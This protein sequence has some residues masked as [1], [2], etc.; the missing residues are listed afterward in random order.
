MLG[1]VTHLL[2]NLRESSR[3]TCSYCV[4][5]DNGDK[6]CKVQA[7]LTQMSL[8]AILSWIR[9]SSA[10]WSWGP[11]A[12]EADFLTIEEPLSR[13]SH[14]GDKCR[15]G[16]YNNTRARALVDHLINSLTFLRWFFLVVDELI[17]V[18]CVLGYKA[19]NILAIKIYREANL[20]YQTFLLVGFKIGFI[21]LR[22]NI[23]YVAS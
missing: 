20:R 13:P 2:G 3:Y 6:N 21:F 1:R 23:L 22:L 16:R 9:A 4:S 15:I 18:R 12:S 19:W 11:I 5:R 8:V 10:G 7:L 14:A 17:R